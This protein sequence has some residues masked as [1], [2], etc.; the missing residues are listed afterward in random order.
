MSIDVPEV[1]DDRNRNKLDPAS[2]LYDATVTG[3]GQLPNDTQID[4]ERVGPADVTYSLVQQDQM[5]DGP[6][7]VATVNIPPPPGSYRGHTDI[8]Q[9]ESQHNLL[10]DRHYT[11]R[12]E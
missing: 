8:S 1:G 12:G 7:V 10:S 2:P 11:M 4:D 9:D 6:E 5:V 3:V